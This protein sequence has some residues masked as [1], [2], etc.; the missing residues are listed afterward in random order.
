VNASTIPVPSQTAE[1][2][3]SIENLPAGYRVKSMTAGTTDVAARGLKL[4]AVAFSPATR[5]ASSIQMVATTG[6]S[7]TL[8]SAAAAQPAVPGAH[9]TGKAQGIARRSIYISGRPGT[10]YSDGTFEFHGVPPGRHTIATIENPESPTPLGASLT[11]GEPDVQ[12]VELE[13]VRLLPSDV[14]TTAPREASGRPQGSRTPLASLRVAIVDEGSGQAAGP[15]TVYVL[16]P[17]GTSFDLPADGRFE[18]ARLL[19]GKYDFEIRVFRH[20]S[21]SRTIVVEDQD[22]ELELK[23]AGDD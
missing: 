8:T 5:N 17:L 13:E 14:R 21:V 18:F 22:V 9:V 23:V 2:Q 16:G 6:L 4:S 11:V 20:A 19:P 12:G 1:Y 7:I 3:V 10:F 15:G